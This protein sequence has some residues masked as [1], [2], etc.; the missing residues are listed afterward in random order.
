MQAA[1]AD[2]AVLGD[3]PDGVAGGGGDHAGPAA[4][5]SSRADGEIGRASCRERV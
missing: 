5:T 2:P 3:V 1:C 4:A